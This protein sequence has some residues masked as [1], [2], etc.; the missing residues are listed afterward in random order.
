MYYDQGKAISYNEKES[1]ES[2]LM[3]GREAP[4]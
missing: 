1:Y 2:S 4:S 3:V